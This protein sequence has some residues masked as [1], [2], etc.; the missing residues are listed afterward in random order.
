MTQAR[1]RGSPAEGRGVVGLVSAQAEAV[2]AVRDAALDRLAMSREPGWLA[3]F[4]KR[5]WDIVEPRYPLVW[6][7]HLS[8]IC[9]ELERVSAGLTSELVICVPPGSAKSMVAS[10]LWP[11]AMWLRDPGLRILGVAHIPKL[12]TRDALRMKDVVLSS[13]YRGLVQR[14]ADEEG[15]GLDDKGRVWDIRKDQREKSNYLNTSRG[16][17][18]TGSIKGGVTGVR[19][20]GAIIDDPYNARTALVGKPT[21]VAERMGEVVTLYDGAIRSRVD[22]RSGW[23]VTIMQRLHDLDLAG[24]L[25]KRG[26]RSVVVP[27]HFDPSHPFRHPRDPRKGEG[28]LFFPQLFD[29]KYIQEVRA[30]KN[31]EL[32]YLAQHQQRP[33]PAAGA[34]FKR[35]WMLQRYQGDPQR[36][37]RSLPEVAITVDCTFKDA[38]SSD[39]VAILVWG[40]RGSQKYLLDVV[41]ARLDLPSTI[42]ALLDIAAKWPQ[43]RLK[44]VEEAANGPGVISML[45][46]HLPGMVGVG[47]TGSKY[48]R[49]QAAAVAFEAGEVW[50]PMAEF[51]PWVSLYVEELCGFPSAANDDQVDATSQ[52]FMRWDGPDGVDAIE[53]M[54][55]QWGFL[56]AKK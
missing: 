52:L 7:W 8:L 51:A 31:G 37:A 30:G 10:V 54:K 4:V 34:L 6:N 53:A 1:A 35:A 26:V 38:Q 28:E 12:A 44:L 49:A 32:V 9:I 27:F 33:S 36:F 24:E 23:I 13:W 14:L 41:R 5:A 20:D 39:Y 3:A 16:S 21:Q 40:R 25:L 19:V 45:K 46:K 42:Q 2:R 56:T 11:A 18:Q 48:S 15:I 29:E 17:R 55:K 50:L 22:S 47:A 43:A